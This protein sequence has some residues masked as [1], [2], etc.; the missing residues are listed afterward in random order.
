MK[1]F[2]T[3]NWKTITLTILGVIFVYLLI[4]VFTPLPDHSELNKYKL[5]QIDKKTEE[6]K[7]LQKDLKDSII[8]YKMKIKDI[9]TKISNIKIKKN[10]INNYY[11]I[12]DEEIKSADKKKI[13]S[14]LRKRYKF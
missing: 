5:E 1:Q 11:T 10:Q 4:R 7:K 14:L 3:Y 12:K 13:D 8:S 2:L 6:I 9:D